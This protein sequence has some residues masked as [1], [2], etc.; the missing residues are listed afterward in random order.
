MVAQRKYAEELRE[1]AVKMVLEVREREGKGHGV[2]QMALRTAS[3]TR[4]CSRVPSS[5]VGLWPPGPRRGGAVYPAGA[6]ARYHPR[7]SRASLNLPT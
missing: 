4:R 1:R 5:G 6:T 7:S 3:W 2:D